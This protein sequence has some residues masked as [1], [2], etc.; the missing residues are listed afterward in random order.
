MC[1]WVVKVG[2]L[3]LC[4]QGALREPQRSCLLVCAKWG[5]LEH[6]LLVGKW[7]VWGA[8]RSVMVEV[9]EG[10]TEGRFDCIPKSELDSVAKEGGE[11]CSWRRH[12]H[13]QTH[14]RFG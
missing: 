4:H 13:E 14:W 2:H 7:V 11:E 5:F 12:R 3:G 10:F 6:K 1:S 8:C 9:T